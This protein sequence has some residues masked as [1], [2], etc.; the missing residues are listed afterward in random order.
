MVMPWWWWGSVNVAELQQQRA[1]AER[2]AAE[3]HERE[4]TLQRQVSEAD[5]ER[6]RND[7]RRAQIEVR[8][9]IPIPAPC[10]WIAY[11][12]GARGHSK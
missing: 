12:R 6:V 11:T 3:L 10:L 2:Q 5:A 9:R 7:G 4:A 8:P 1:D